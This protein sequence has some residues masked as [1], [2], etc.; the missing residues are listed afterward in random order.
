V[1]KYRKG[2]GGVST[3]QRAWVIRAAVVLFAAATGIVGV[4]SPALAKAP[5]VQITLPNGQLQSGG[6]T[7]LKFTITNNNDQTVGD[8]SAHV[9]VRFTGDLQGVMSCQGQ[10]QF[11]QPVPDGQTS[12]E[13]SATLS[14]GSVDP[15]QTKAGKVEIDVTIAGESANE[16]AD[17][18]VS[19]PAQQQSVPQLSGQ[20]VDIFKGSGIANARVTAQDSANPP[21]NWAVGTD[22]DG[23]FRI[24]STP[25]KPITPGVIAF[26][27]TKDGYENYQEAKQGV[28]GQAITNLHFAMK[29]TVTSGPPTSSSLTPT[30]PPVSSI[31]EGNTVGATGS[32]GGGGLSWLLI[33]IGGVLVALGVAAIV[34]LL[35]RRKGD[36]DDDD[37]TVGRGPG[38]GGPGRGGPRPPHPPSRRAPEPTA[39][40]RGGPG[41]RPPG[42][43]RGDQTMIARSPLADV[44]TQMHG[45]VG[46]HGGPP[47][48]GYG[49]NPY[50]SGQYGGQGG[51]GGYGN[52]GYP[53][54]APPNYGQPDPYG[55]AYGPQQYQGGYGQPPHGGAHPPGH[56][57]GEPDPRAPRQGTPPHDRRVDW[58]DD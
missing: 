45:R 30:G 44:P 25:D 46:P 15:G 17:L 35:I 21:H 1:L 42:G 38:R 55:N 27:V 5:T 14:A 40:M 28:A 20:V 16:S 57:Q 13:F 3:H 8:T 43:P 26:V 51:P 18:S 56:G 2:R 41:G 4:A 53:G 11:V 33:A 19:G 54:G 48:P 32:G 58:L 12:P 9:N 7:S 29:P 36:E 10:C 47:P 50:A 52:P 34:I 6:S 23:K 22:K 31:D 37:A 49:Q 24:V 39:V